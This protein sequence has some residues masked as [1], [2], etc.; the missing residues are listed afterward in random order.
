MLSQPGH[1]HLPGAPPL[2]R[3]VS[4]FLCTHDANAKRPRVDVSIQKNRQIIL[5]YNFLVPIPNT[6]ERI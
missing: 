2:D 4:Q 1:G 5:S 6:R 3:S